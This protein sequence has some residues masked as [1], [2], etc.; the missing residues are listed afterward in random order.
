MGDKEIVENIA[1]LID[2]L[3][4]KRGKI[5]RYWGKGPKGC[6]W[7]YKI[8]LTALGLWRYYQ[9]LKRI[10]KNY[11]EIASLWKKREKLEKH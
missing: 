2:S 7:M 3:G 1:R 11:G 6:S 4:Y 10:E 9:D 5:K 8:N